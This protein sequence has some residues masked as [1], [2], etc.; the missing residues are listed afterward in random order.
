[1]DQ[2]VIVYQNHLSQSRA[3]DFKRSS[4]TAKKMKH[5]TFVL[6]GFYWNTNEFSIRLYIIIIQSGQNIITQH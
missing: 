4:F 6:V 3:F 2:R 1:M 5:D